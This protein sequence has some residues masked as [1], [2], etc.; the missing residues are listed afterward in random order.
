MPAYDF[1]YLWTNVQKL[2]EQ[3]IEQNKQQNSESVNGSNMLNQAKSSFK[4]MK[5]PKMK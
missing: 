2:I 1:M 5:S 3:E 4:G